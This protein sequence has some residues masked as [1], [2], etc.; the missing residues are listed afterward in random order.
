MFWNWYT[1]D[2]CFL[3][4]TWRITSTGMFVGSCF[5]VFGLVILLECLRRVQRE[6]DRFVQHSIPP[7]TTREHSPQR[8]S[9]SVHARHENP[10]SEDFCMSSWDVSK[11]DSEAPVPPSTPLLVSPLPSEM[12]ASDGR[13]RKFYQAP[14]IVQHLIRSTLYT[15]QL[16]VAYTIMLLAMY[17]NGYILGSVF[18]GAFVGSL[19]CGWDVLSVQG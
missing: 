5:G 17:Y 15:C 4:P 13:R 3:S 1:V 11:S 10:P 16:A 19:I 9:N 2:T 18:I 12:A 8:P 7:S 6:F 14:V